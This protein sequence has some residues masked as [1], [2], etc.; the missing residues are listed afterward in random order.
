M[1]ASP[2]RVQVVPDLALVACPPD[3]DP[4][5]REFSDRFS[6]VFLVHDE[7]VREYEFAWILSDKLL[8]HLL[9]NEFPWNAVGKIDWV[10]DLMIAFEGWHRTLNPLPIEHCP[11]VQVEPDITPSYIGDETRQAWLDVLAGCVQ[12][13]TALSY[14]ASFLQQPVVRLRVHLNAS[15]SE[16][17]LIRQ[18][19]EWDAVLAQVD[20][21]FKHSLPRA[22]NHSYEPPKSWRWGQPFPRG[23]RGIGFLDV[24]GRTWIWDREEEH[25]DVQDRR[26]GRGRY[27]RVT[28][29][30]RRLESK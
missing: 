10:T 7:K 15:A 19:A 8:L 16:I 29:G 17:E 26:S 3:P 18:I 30:G 21:W 5:D 2:S 6:Q 9:G 13:D 27:I 28:S 24:K 11:S 22:R 14:I 4:W 1:T 12:T 20:P 23:E 25:W